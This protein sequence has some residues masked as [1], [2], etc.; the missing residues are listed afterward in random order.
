MTGNYFQKNGVSIIY[1][2]TVDVLP[3]LWSRISSVYYSQCVS[4]FDIL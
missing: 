3:L 1:V 4:I 2:Q